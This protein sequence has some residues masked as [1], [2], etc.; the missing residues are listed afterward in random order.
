MGITQ[1][2]PYH[3]GG[4]DGGL[5]RP[6][7]RIATRCILGI[8]RS[9]GRATAR[10]TY[11][12]L[13]TRPGWRPRAART[14]NLERQRL[15]MSEK[16]Q[17]VTH[18]G[19]PGIWVMKG[20]KT[21]ANWVLS[22]ISNRYPFR[23]GVSF[24]VPV[25][26][27]GRPLGRNAINSLLGH[28]VLTGVAGADLSTVNSRPNPLLPP[29]TKRLR[30]SQKDLPV[31]IFLAIWIAIGVFVDLFSARVNYLAA[32]RSYGASGIPFAATLLF[33]YWLPLLT[34][35][36]AVITDWWLKDAGILTVFNI[37]LGVLFQVLHCRWVARRAPSPGTISGAVRRGISRKLRPVLEL[38]VAKDYA[39]V[40]AYYADGRVTGDVL[41]TDVLRYG[42]TLKMP[43]N[44]A[45]DGIEIHPV[46]EAGNEWAGVVDLWSK[47]EGRSDLSLEFTCT[48]TVD[49]TFCFVVDSIRVM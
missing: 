35:E 8:F 9:T 10:T 34:T 22:G 29:S 13:T 31:T 37:A 41:E 2:L 19:P 17:T 25:S 49:G 42:R 3:R 39:G 44:T 24:Q 28:R 11:T 1:R 7:L 18:W 30:S 32:E 43:P 45:L 4:A 48:K 27:L 46:G 23:G 33:F 38:L 5:L 12:L 16:L 26:A 40:A 14:S 47:E 15:N 21:V 36:H 6:R 20:G